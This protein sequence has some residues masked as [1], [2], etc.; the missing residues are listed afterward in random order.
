MLKNYLKVALRNLR[1]H[2]GY[3]VINVLGLSI[4]MMCCV[5]IFLY[6]ADELS[7]DRFHANADQIYRLRIERYSSGGESELT[8]SASAPMTPAI[9]QDHPQVEQAVRISQRTY[10]V[11]Q[12]DRRF[13]EEDFFWADSSFF[14][15]FSFD[16]LRGDPTT[17][18]TAPFSVVLTESMAAKYFGREDPMGQILTM[19]DRDLRV[20]GVVEDAPEQSHFAF[21]FLGSFTTLEAFRGSPSS[22][23]NWW[24]LSFHTYLLL[25][26]GTPVEALQEQLRELP[27]RYIGNQESG[28][29]YR[30]FLYLQP[31]TEIHLN[32]HYRY[33]LKPN[34]YTAYVYVFSAIALFI[35]VLACINFMNLAT[36]RSVQR[37]QE[38]G[39]RKV[40][41]ARK[42]QMVKQFLGESVF[43]SL[44]ALML[45]LVLI[46]VAL[47]LFNQLAAKALSFHYVGQASLV[48][49]LVG[50]AVMVGLVAG[51]YPALV[52]SSF[53][54]IDV[55]K[56]Q[57]RSGTS[58]AFLRQ[59]LVVFQFAVS[60]GLSS[61][62]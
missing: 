27:S 51:S 47:P 11:E 2:K 49:G 34:S 39:M 53:R 6:V 57:F 4:G 52:L 44:L 41:G 61:A 54:P 35:L 33:E 13:Y 22:E 37:A 18:L 62:R 45:A 30:Q 31:L 23:W 5:L 29:G 25:A 43:L 8:S 58:G 28:S 19:D 1:K 59:G 42:G 10:L 17:A 3:T 9:L 26:E 32:S 40:L 38:V 12:A 24:N 20:T 48:L 56:G 21:D 16:L 55:F 36:A 14:E 50:F 46:Q 60:V 7:F 15:V